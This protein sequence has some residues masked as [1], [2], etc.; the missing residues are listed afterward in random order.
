MLFR[1]VLWSVSGRRVAHPANQDQEVTGAHVGESGVASPWTSFAWFAALFALAAL[2]GYILAVAIF[3]P[4]FVRKR[5]NRG[6]GMTVAFTIA[7][8]ASVLLLGH[9]LS[10][11]FPRGLLQE[12]VDLPWPLN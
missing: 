1:S 8:I 4:A 11:D 10:L 7:M 2:V 3:F 9:A 5:A 6:W 12:F